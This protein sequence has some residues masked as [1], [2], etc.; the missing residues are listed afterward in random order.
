MEG[1]PRSLATFRQSWMAIGKAARGGYLDPGSAPM[2]AEVL[3][4]LL[5]ERGA[6][7]GELAGR[8]LGSPGSQIWKHTVG[9]SRWTPGGQRH[10]KEGCRGL[11]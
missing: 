3:W 7:Q 5:S 1:T 11:G 6:G 2:V 8:G 9:S 4:V 10:L